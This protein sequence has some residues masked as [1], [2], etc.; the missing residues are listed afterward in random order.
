M[1]RGEIPVAVG[2]VLGSIL[3]LRVAPRFAVEDERPLPTY[4]LWMGIAGLVAT[5][6]MI[7][8]IAATWMLADDSVVLAAVVA[9]VLW[10]SLAIP[11]FNWGMRTMVA[12][13]K[14]QAPRPPGKWR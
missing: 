2:L 7:V 13:E 14:A 12:R 4:L 11:A 9:L 6:V 1:L 3:S 8:G 5:S 10:L